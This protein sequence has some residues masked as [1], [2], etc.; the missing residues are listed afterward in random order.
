M[1]AAEQHF[2]PSV[3]NNWRQQQLIVAL[4]D[5]KVVL[6]PVLFRLRRNRRL[7]AVTYRL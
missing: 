4:G 1:S 6:S 2:Q 5:N 3:G 7:A